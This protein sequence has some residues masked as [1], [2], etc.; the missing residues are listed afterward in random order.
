M[1]IRDPQNLISSGI[2]VRDNA[3]SLDKEDE[4]YFYVDPGPESTP[5]SIEDPEDSARYAWKVASW[6]IVVLTLI[7]NLIIVGVIVIN[8]NANSVVNK[9]NEK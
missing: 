5:E 4:D 2:K 9:G 3:M 1:L 6:I 7:C 8:R